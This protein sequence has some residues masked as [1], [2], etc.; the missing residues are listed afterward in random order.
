MM[1]IEAS[2]VIPMFPTLVW[3]VSLKAESRDV[4]ATDVLALLTELR[5]DLPPLEPGQGWQSEQTLH[6]HQELRQLHSCVSHVARR[7]L[8]FLRIGQESLESNRLLGHCSGQGR[9]AQGS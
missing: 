5:R 2:D 7:I 3:K 6:E 9:H 4:I 8:R 1:W